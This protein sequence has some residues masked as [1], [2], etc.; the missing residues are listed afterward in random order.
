MYFV[1]GFDY[2]EEKGVYNKQTFT[3]YEYEDGE[4]DMYLSIQPMLLPRRQ[5]QQ[6]LAIIEMPSGAKDYAHPNS[7][8][9]WSEPFQAWMLTEPS[10]PINHIVLTYN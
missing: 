5:K 2:E 7:V 10:N 4:E 6:Y 3:Q 8:F 1:I 9:E